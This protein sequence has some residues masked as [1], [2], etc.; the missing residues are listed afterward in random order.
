MAKKKP[1]KSFYTDRT[2]EFHEYANIYPLMGL[3]EIRKHGKSIKEFGQQD[4]IVLY[5]GQILDGRNTY[6]ACHQEG[7]TPRFCYYGSHLDPLDYVKIKNDERRQMSTAQSAA[8]A[9]AFLQIE[10]R[11]AQERIS[12]T[13]FNNHKNRKQKI[14]EKDTASNPGSLAVK[15]RAIDIVA[16]EHKI[17]P[18]TLI[19]AEKIEKA[20]QLDP[21]IKEKWEKAK[22]N[23]LSLEEVYRAVIKK[24]EANIK[25]GIVVKFVE[26]GCTLPKKGITNENQWTENSNL[27]KKERIQENKCKYCSKAT[28][29]A[30][31]CEKCG[32]PT[33]RVFCDNDF[34]K[35]AKR[36]L[37]PDGKK[38]E[39]FSVPD[40]DALSVGSTLG[41]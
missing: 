17:A 13:Q 22:N 28:V 25:K 21:E 37:N 24:N 2:Y 9:L 5:E 27:K 7:I 16:K 3:N 4:D 15:G 14:N 41:R 26:A 39:E 36:L 33:P 19:K 23:E 8:S 12:R 18:K 40:K 35:N 6:L 29:F 32:H 38:C 20:A 34:I 11:R 30:I 1:Q 10:R 31:T